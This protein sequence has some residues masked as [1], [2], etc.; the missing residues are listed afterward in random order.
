MNYGSIQADFKALYPAYN[1]FPDTS[2]D[3]ANL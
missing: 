2:I 3:K 1:L